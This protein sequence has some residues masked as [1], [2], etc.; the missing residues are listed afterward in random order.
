MLCRMLYLCRVFSC[1]YTAKLVVCRVP[2]FWHSAKLL[3]LGKM[4]ISGS[5]C[6]MEAPDYDHMLV[7]REEITDSAISVLTNST[8]VP[9]RYIRTEEVLDGEIV[10]E[11][12]GYELPVIDMAKL[13]DPAFS[14]SETAKLGS[15]C[16]NWGF[17]QLAN[18]G[19]DEAV[20][21][22]MKDNTLQFFSLPLES[23]KA[24]AVRGNGFQGF[25]HHY[26]SSTGKLD[27][28]E[29]LTVT[30][31]PVGDRN[32]EMWPTNPPNFRY[33]LENY[34]VETT[35][36][37]M[38]LLGFMAADL[39]V[40]REVLQGAFAGQRQNMTIH[41]YPPC[42]HKEKVMGIVPHTDR[43]GLTL[44][45]HVDDTPGLQ[46]RKDTR[47]FPF[48]PLPGAF[49]VNV[50]DILEVLTNGMYRGVEHR[51]IPD[52]ER[53]RTT[54]VMLHAA[55]I[56]GLVTLLPELLK[57]AEARYESINTPSISRETARRWL[58]GHS[59]SRA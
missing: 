26:T 58:M 4:P 33:A 25:G 3:V 53:G 51:V 14:A 39:G 49:V 17:F 41:H 45:L 52:S 30:V 11:D 15:A 1:Q 46:I 50:G 32:M 7:N 43:L 37:V 6:I 44:L 5:D 29:S 10:G 27:W 22:R 56:R 31:Q 21:Q 47:W 23:K 8:H 54:I 55:S 42:H 16:R 9:E 40:E 13:L 2:D 19:F 38:R 48:R 35:D 57:G 18:H 59:S 34:S 24:V 20:M 28:A 36:L 12:E